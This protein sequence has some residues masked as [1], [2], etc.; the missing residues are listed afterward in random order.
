MALMQSPQ[1]GRPTDL[2]GPA[3]AL[4]GTIGSSRAQQALL[5]ETERTELPAESRKQALAGFAESVNRYGVLL[6]CHPLQAAYARY[7]QSSVSAD[8]A[9]AGAV[10][11]VIETPSRKARPV[12]ADAAHPRPTR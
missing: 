11:D 1:P 2:F 9:V 10:L 8:R 6:E 3:A 4:L 5:G 7:N 12:S